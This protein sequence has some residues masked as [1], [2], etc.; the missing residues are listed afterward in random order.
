MKLSK[1]KLDS[2][3][4]IIEL[5]VATGVVTMVMVAVVSGVSMSIK[6]SRYSKE[7]AQSARLSQDVVEW[8]RG[9]RD[10]M[11]WLNFYNTINGDKPSPGLPD[12]E[13]VYCLDVLPTEYTAFDGLDVTTD[14]NS[15]TEFE[16]EN[17]RRVAI[18]TT[19]DDETMNIVVRVFWNDG[20]GDRSTQIETSLTQW[21]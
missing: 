10:V 7:K 20:S 17:F 5:L 1:S 11:G 15:C 18:I 3:F 16:D 4:A 19:P 14:I 9:R 12:T 6:N 8:L 13:I 2:G 21:R